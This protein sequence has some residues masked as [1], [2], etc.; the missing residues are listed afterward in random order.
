M[1]TL[2]NTQ[3]T[4]FIE[5]GYVVVPGLLSPD[6]VAETKRRLLE[7]MEID[8]NDPDSWTDK[9]S[10]RQDAEVIAVTEAAR[11]RE[12]EQVTAELVG[13]N[14]LR[15]I[16][17]SP[18]LEWN[19]QPPMCRGYIPVL[20]YPTP[21]EKRFVPPP[22]YHIDG[23]KYGTTYPERYFL[24][25]MA[26]LSDVCEYGGATAVRPGSHRQVFENWLAN[27]HIPE[28]PFA[29]VP[30]LEYADPIPVTANAGDVCFMHYLMVHSGSENRA[31]TIRI[32][33]NTAVMP[34]PV[35]P[36]VP[37]IGKPTAS[38]TPMDYTLRTDNL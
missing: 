32:G 34:D 15:G 24:A 22:S 18:N 19:G 38:W 5:E 35:N 33:M 23:G 13:E 31:D 17:F 1:I 4:Q 16:C 8:E 2:T 6:L 7:S 37:R 29:I 26:Y 10:V 21:G 36:Y 28:D 3:K 12:F 27:E 11:T 9:P 20:T 25:V 14:F 30:S